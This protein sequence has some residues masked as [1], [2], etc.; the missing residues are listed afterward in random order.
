MIHPTAIVH[1]NARLAADVEVGA[2]SIIGGNVGNAF[3]ID[4][5]TGQVFLG[6]TVDCARCHDHKIDPIPQKDYYRLV[7]FFRNINHYRNGGPTDEAPIFSAPDGKERYDDYL[8][9]LTRRRDAI[10]VQVTALEAEL[11]RAYEAEQGVKVAGS[12]LDD[13]RY[14][15]YRDTWDHLPE[16]DALKP[17]ET[18]ELPGRLFDLGPRSRNEAFGFVEMLQAVKGKGQPEHIADVV[19]FLASEDARWITGQTLNVDAGMVRH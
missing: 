10:Q 19:S 13:V 16:F 5:T 18:G 6:L 14:R 15:F 3:R 9:T 8:R 11:R 4:A 7:S 12:D 17:E 1:P 2:Y